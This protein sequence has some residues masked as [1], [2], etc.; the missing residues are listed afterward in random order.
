MHKVQKLKK[1]IKI[2]TFSRN[3][4]PLTKQWTSVTAS[5]LAGAKT[6]AHKCFKSFC[7]RPAH[8]FAAGTEH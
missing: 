4:F 2:C 5:S 3:N 1:Y 8:Q 6:H 7:W